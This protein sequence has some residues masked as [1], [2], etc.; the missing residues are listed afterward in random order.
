MLTGR[1]H[2]KDGVDSLGGHISM[3]V[4]VKEGRVI[5]IVVDD[6]VYLVARGTDAVDDDPPI[7]V[8]PLG[9]I[10]SQY[11][12]EV[13]LIDITLRA[14]M[15]NTLAAQLQLNL[16]QLVLEGK[17]I[18]KVMPAVNGIALVSCHGSHQTISDQ[19]FLERD[20]V[21]ATLM[22]CFSADDRSSEM[23]LLVF[24]GSTYLLLTKLLLK[25][26]STSQKLS[27][28]AVYERPERQSITANSR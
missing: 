12:D 18:L 13:I 24:A 28:G 10:P 16:K 14:R 27:A 3:P 1:L 25:K 5:L 4:L 21:A 20:I 2:F 7:H 22:A 6:D 9:K 17:G 23:T 19:F 11:C 8:V 26:P 15:G